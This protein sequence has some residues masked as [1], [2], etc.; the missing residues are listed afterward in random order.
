MDPKWDTIPNPDEQRKHQRMDARTINQMNNERERRIAAAEE[1][2]N[3]TELP[4]EK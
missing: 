2:N 1:K 3:A 4:R